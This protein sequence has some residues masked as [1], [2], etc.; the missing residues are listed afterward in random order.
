MSSG[1]SE[2]DLVESDKSV[3]HNIGGHPI[4]ELPSMFKYGF[5]ET[6]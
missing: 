2:D 4:W 5:P 6:L 1:E 3:N